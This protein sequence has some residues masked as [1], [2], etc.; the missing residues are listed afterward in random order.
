MLWLHSQLFWTVLELTF[1]TEDCNFRLYMVLVMHFIQEIRSHFL[2]KS[3]L[4]RL[5]RYSHSKKQGIM[6]GLGTMYTKFIPKIDLK[7]LFKSH[8]INH[9]TTLWGL[10]GPRNILTRAQEVKGTSYRS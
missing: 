2:K 4:F 10:C 1:Y 6:I 8:L 7:E 9:Q 3:V 5:F